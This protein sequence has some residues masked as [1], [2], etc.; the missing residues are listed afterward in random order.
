[1]MAELDE[2]FEQAVEV[3]LK[4]KSATTSII[5]KYLKL[6]YTKAARI[7]DQLEEMGMIGPSCGADPRVILITKDLWLLD[8]NNWLAGKYAPPKQ[9]ATSE[10]S[11]CT[12]EPDKQESEYDLL[13]VSTQSSIEDVKKAYYQK[14]KEYHPDKTSGLGEKLKNLALEE[15]K[16]INRAYEAIKKKKGF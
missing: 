3:I 15:S 12:S 13:G 10:Q 6:G 4:R 11:D 16:K 1:M 14:M 8:R 7:M 2:L 5:Q 9:E